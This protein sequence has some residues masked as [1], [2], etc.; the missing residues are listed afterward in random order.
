M[1]VIF[2]LHCLTIG[3]ICCSFSTLTHPI[4]RWRLFS[5]AFILGSVVLS[6]A[7][8]AHAH[9]TE[10]VLKM[11]YD[12]LSTIRNISIF[13]S[14]VKFGQ[15]SFSLIMLLLFWATDFHTKYKESYP[16][17][18]KM[19]MT[20]FWK[21]HFNFDINSIFGKFTVR[22]SFHLMSF[23]ILLITKIFTGEASS[24]FIPQYN[25]IYHQ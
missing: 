15:S 9:W 23:F 5:K 19:W 3:F 25:A 13:S 17:N 8:S 10:H 14:C 21:N 16:K 4:H 22:K 1:A 24:V 6:Y 11:A 2:V 18:S 7:S 12:G 20:T